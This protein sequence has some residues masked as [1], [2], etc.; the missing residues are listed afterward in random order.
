MS[1]IQ[2]L[3]QSKVL[4]I[5]LGLTGSSFAR[6]LKQHDIAFDAWDTRA[7]D[8]VNLAGCWQDVTCY[9]AEQLPSTH[10]DF[11]LI[12]PGVDPRHQFIQE[13]T[14]SGCQLIGDIELFNQLRST[15]II[16]VTG[17]NGKST[18]CDWIASLLELSGY[19]VGLGGNIGTPAL[20]LLE[21]AVDYYV[22]E[23][24]SFQLETVSQ[25]NADI[26]IITNIAPDHL[27]RYDS[28]DDYFAAK[29]R[30]FIGAKSKIYPQDYLETNSQQISY[31]VEGSDSRSLAS[32][33]DLPKL[34]L[35]LNGAHN[36]LNALLVS[37][38]GRILGLEPKVVSQALEVYKGLAHRCQFVGAYNGVSWFDDSK[39]TNVAAVVAALSGLSTSKNIILLVGGVAKEDDFSPLVPFVQ[40]KVKQV[41][42][43]GRDGLKIVEQLNHA[44][45]IE[46]V[47]GLQ[48][49]TRLAADKAVDGDMVLLS[50]ACASFDEFSN[51]IQRGEKFVEYLEASYDN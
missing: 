17:T 26:A 50:P 22:L 23:L 2:R 51:Y 25:L 34:E 14:E 3:Q 13:L 30:I 45:P 9:F 28:F 32:L 12:S 40:S 46:T 8:A 24:S 38:V 7:Q 48:A 18:V 39:A 35:Q 29:Q 6:W 1:I 41:V 10:Y 20:E 36:Q 11:A 47:E 4:V 27:D 44:A 33:V 37:Q 16:A 5:G 19:K 43:Y 31:W 21:Q 15:P 49:A 42:A